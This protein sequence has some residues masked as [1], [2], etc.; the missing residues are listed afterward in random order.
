MGTMLS[1]WATFLYLVLIYQLIYSIA[2]CYQQYFTLTWAMSEL[3]VRHH[4]KNLRALCAAIILTA[5]IYQL[6]NFHN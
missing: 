3:N 2:N 6:T 1:E 5:G 4:F